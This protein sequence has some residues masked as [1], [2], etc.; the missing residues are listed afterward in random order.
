MKLRFSLFGDE[1]F[2]FGFTI[3][4][5]HDRLNKEYIRHS[6]YHPKILPPMQRCKRGIFVDVD[7]IHHLRALTPSL[8]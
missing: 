6:A 4:E 7:S 5:I 1:G 2:I 3:T 8:P